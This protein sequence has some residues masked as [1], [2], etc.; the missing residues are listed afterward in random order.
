MQPTIEI[1]TLLSITL[2]LLIA[3]GLIVL[4]RAFRYPLNE[5]FRKL[6]PWR[7]NRR[8]EQLQS[9]VEDIE[10]SC[11]ELRMKNKSQSKKIKALRKL[12]KGNLVNSSKRKKKKKK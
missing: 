8:I 3:I 2:Y 1:T 12:N 6:N 9:R 11:F 5:I 4:Y 7:H 10:T